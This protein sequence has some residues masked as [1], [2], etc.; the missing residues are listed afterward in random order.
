[1]QTKAKLIT[2]KPPMPSLKALEEAFP[3]KGYELRQLLKGEVKTNEYLSVQ[4]L[5]RSCYNRPFY[6]HRL[7][8]ALNEI[9][10]G[11][12]VERLEKNGLPFADY[13]NMGD[14]YTTTLIRKI[15]SGTV[16]IRDIGSF[17]ESNRL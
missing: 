17:I 5:E 9:I 16:M 10:E 6:S 11:F 14:V 2:K 13:V 15:D 12:S 1:M 8:V 4:D 7:M 3:G